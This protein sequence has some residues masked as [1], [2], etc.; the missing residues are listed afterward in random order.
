MACNTKH[1]PAAAIRYYEKATGV[2]LTQEDWHLIREA[3]EADKGG[4]LS[5]ARITEHEAANA[6]M[7][8]AEATNTDERV[9]S[10]DVD[11]ACAEFV[12][13]DNTTGTVEMLRHLSRKGLPQTVT[14]RT[15]RGKAKSLN[16]ASEGIVGSVASQC[17]ACGQFSAEGHVCPPEV[18]RAFAVSHDTIA[19]DLYDKGYRLG[20][21]SKMLGD[22]LKRTAGHER[23]YNYSGYQGSVEDAIATLGAGIAKAQATDTYLVFRKRASD[24]IKDI[25]KYEQT[26]ADLKVINQ[27]IDDSETIYESFGWSRAFL[28]VA[29]SGGHV[30]S[31]MRC[32]TCYPTTKFN[33][34]VDYSGA[35]EDDIVGDAGERACTVCY[36]TA[37]VDVLS[38][39]SKIFSEEERQKVA[40]RDARRVAL[41]EKKAKAALKA[42]TA[43]GSELVVVVDRGINGQHS[44][45]PGQPYERKTGFKTEQA[46]YNWMTERL[47]Y[48][49]W[50]NPNNEGQV[51]GL[52]EAE[53]EAIETIITSL[54]H[55]HGVP[56]ATIQTELD[57]KLAAR[58]KRNR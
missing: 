41:A 6:F 7:E 11:D 53:S 9:P 31:S 13:A 22:D 28:V 40:E 10:Y 25:E 52:S 33:W 3:A 36:P 35:D 38:R 47:D 42:A 21:Q 30:H 44:R 2:K 17:L 49:Q 4:K 54:A 57:R 18:L 16:A 32:S 39:P 5:R 14:S 1:G 56:T 46:A 15:R 34:C 50:R 24:I 55:K 23:N 12:R 48:A 26:V 51:K 58:L 27:K 8:L 45:N 43:D 20:L 29:N 19:A 37:P